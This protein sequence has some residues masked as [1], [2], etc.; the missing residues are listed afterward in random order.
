MGRFMSM[1]LLLLTFVGGASA[2]PLTLTDVDFT[3]GQGTLTGY[4]QIDSTNGQ[5]IDWNLQTSTYDCNPCSLSTGFPGISYAPGTSSA[6][7]SF[8]SG[9]QAISFD[10][11]ASTWVLAFVLNCGG[12]GA[13]CLGTASEGD[14]IALHS[15]FEMDAVDFLPYRELSLGALEVSDPP[16]VLTFNV[17]GPNNPVPEPATLAL[18]SIGLVGALSLRRR[19]AR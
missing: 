15:A 11:N 7:V 16:G 10:D 12:N 5:V 18:L 17:V 19:G 8:I 14:R 4:F 1:I 3:N 13:D 9:F 6:A 2:A